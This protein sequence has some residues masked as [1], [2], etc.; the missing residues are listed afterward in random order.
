MSKFQVLEPPL[1]SQGDKKEYRLIKLTNGLK[2]L[3][4]RRTTD[5]A[6]SENVAAANITVGV[7]S[8]DDP[9]NA[10][11][12]AHFLE[13]MVHMGSEKYPQESEYNDFLT[14]NG[15]RRNATTSS[16]YSSYFFSVSEKAFPEAL[17][18]FE[19]IIESPLLLKNSM[20]REREAVDSEYKMHRFSDD[21]RLLSIIEHLISD[22]HPA[23]QFSIGNLTTLKEDITDEDL[24][25]ELIKLHGKYVAN[26]MCLAIQSS[27]TLDEMQTLVVEKFSGI[28]RG[29]EEEKPILSID[30]IFKPEFFSKIYYM[31]PK[32]PKKAL[33]MSWPIPPLL[34]HYKCSP[35]EYIQHIFS[36]GGD[37]GIFNFLREQ[38]LITN[39]DIYL[40]PNS[41][42]SNSDFTLVRLLADLT[43][44]GLENIEKVLEGIFSYLLMIKDTPM[45]E[46]RRLYA[47]LKEKS[48]VD[49]NFHKEKSSTSNVANF[50]TDM[51]FYEESDILRGARVY[52]QFD[53]Q[54]IRMCIDALNERKFNIIVITEKREKYGITEKYFGTEYDEED[55][56]EAYKTLWNERRP[57][58]EFYLQR[59]NPFK[60]TKFEIFVNDEES[61]VSANHHL[62]KCFSTLRNYLPEISIKSVSRRIGPRVAQAR[63]EIQNASRPIRGSARFAHH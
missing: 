63:Q 28:K 7:G 31:K 44:F 53:E 18:R 33:M 50:A 42:I 10:L 61:P 5:E 20:Q 35:L 39:I 49:F 34:S 60:T 21:V 16:Q 9:C 17:D 30:Q 29:G 2:A 6:D 26:K 59:P 1:K 43:D 22:A 15:G 54:S 58:R 40:E 24:H 56:P 47:E 8:F 48:E 46:H 52:Q 51:L 55:F 62:P 27:R 37:G 25:T 11:G 36:N 45:E 41:E 14:S 4:V 13:H 57:N 38:H 12:L 3:L 23:S 32:T 19:Q